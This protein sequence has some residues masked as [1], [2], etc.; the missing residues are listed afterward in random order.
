MRWE[1]KERMCEGVGRDGM[2]GV[3]RKTSGGRT[4]KRGRGREW[5]AGLV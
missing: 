1:S 5:D 3:R 2:G 4:D